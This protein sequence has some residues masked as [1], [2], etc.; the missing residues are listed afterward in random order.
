[1]RQFELTP[2]LR[3]LADLAGNCGSIWDVGTDHGKLPVWLLINGRVRF[4]VASDIRRGPLES[5]G[6][7]AEAHNVKDRMR[8]FLCDGLD[9]PAEQEIDTITIAGMG[10]DTIAGILDRAPWVVNNETRLLL[11]PMSSIEDLREFLFSGAYTVLGEHLVR[12]RDKLYLI[13]EAKGGGIPEPYDFTDARIGKHLKND[14]EFID[15][16]A[17]EIRRLNNELA[18]ADPQKKV[19]I[20]EAIRKIAAMKEEAEFEHSR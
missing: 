3:M 16:A 4:A 18:G 15:Y 12:E 1:L 20:H 9:A 6:K 8:F 11:Q 10:G 7:T 5:A 19:M 14:K 2:R 13:I 17:R